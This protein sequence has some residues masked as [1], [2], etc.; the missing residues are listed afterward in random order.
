MDMQSDLDQERQAHAP[1][2]T[3]VE[4]RS[5]SLALVDVEEEEIS[6]ETPIPLDRARAFLARGEG[7]PQEEILREFV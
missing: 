7:I 4:S 5:V 6:A 3:T 2:E 1:L